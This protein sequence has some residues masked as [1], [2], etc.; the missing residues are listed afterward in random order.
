[1][2][3]TI[4]I[5]LSIS[6]LILLPIGLLNAKNN[7]QAAILFQING[8]VKFDKQLNAYF[9]NIQARLKKEGIQTVKIQDIP[10]SDCSK[11][12]CA[13]DI[14]KKQSIPYLVIVNVNT[15]EVAVAEDFKKYLEIDKAATVY[16]P[17]VILIETKT[18]KQSNLFSDNNLN[19]NAL[20]KTEPPIATALSNKLKPS[21]P[22]E[23]IAGTYYH[24]LTVSALWIKPIKPYTSI[25]SAGLGV[26]IK[27]S[28]DF[29]SGTN[30]KI[31]S[32]LQ[33]S[34]LLTN[35]DSIS[36]AY[37]A[38]LNVGLGYTI[39]SGNI[40]KVTP[41]I[42]AGYAFNYTKSKKNL[43]IETNDGFSGHPMINTGFE[44]AWNIT[45]SSSLVLYPSLSVF[46]GEESPCRYFSL[47]VGNQFSF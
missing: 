19:I 28:Y 17:R 36:S 40:L 27:Y 12:K 4:Y 33:V 16:S 32:D 42:G 3:R 45:K 1:M 6:L 21:T 29:F 2:I 15:K 31:L 5:T 20:R 43:A 22:Q 37:F 18:G 46:F 9:N 13:L 11:I 24:N 14:C 10:S 39:H 34:R 23:T 7:T 47:A 41:V 30:F 44:F 26:D 8:E 35:K 25:V 38:S